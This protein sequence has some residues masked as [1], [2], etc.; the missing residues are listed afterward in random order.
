MTEKTNHRIIIG[1]SRQMK[2][3]NAESVQLI[4]TSPP[5][6]QLKDYGDP[7]QI[8]FDDSYEDYINNL[9]LVW[10]ECNR[11][12]SPGC[13]LCINI[14]DQFA[15][16]VY[17]G[18]YKVI[19]IRT[20]I[21]KFCETI[22][23]DYM[24]AIIWQKVTTTNTTGGATIMGSFPYP[25]NGILK[26]DYEFILIFKKLGTA[27]KPTPYQ[28]EKSK[29]TIDE[30]NE[31]FA[32][33]WNFNG[34]K[35]DKH[36]AM[37]PEELPRRLIRMFSFVGDTILD[38]FLGSG[39]TSLAA[40]NLGRNSIGYEI[41]REFTN[42]IKR[43]LNSAPNDLFVKSDVIMSKQEYLGI[44]YKALINTLPYKYV[45]NKKINK[46]IDP[47][48]IVFGSKITG[49]E[50][51]KAE[52]YRMK[53]VVDADTIE[54]NTGAMIR[55]MGIIPIASMRKEAI[56]YLVNVLTGQDIFLKFDDI[57]YDEQNNLLAYVY[58]K[59]K[60][61]INAKMIKAGFT[62]PAGDY[63]FKYKDKFNSYV[64]QKSLSD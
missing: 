7:N 21:T 28:K 24:G 55:L 64:G 30:W 58:L 57:K 62:S 8:G 22:G 18:R 26:I 27:P 41:N 52:Y 20:E 6:W 63:D 42:I 1:D 9:N 48:K 39:T 44:D 4:I 37:F 17:Y 29:L 43:K 51:H 50:A 19:P 56:N 12:L 53:R 13:R 38:P 32:G 60:T 16:S 33:H 34:E 23:L 49:K 2:E 36:L 15:R 31:Y 40:M 14:G 46:K 61:F 54:L 35:Q 5:Y 25:R 3:V 10:N 47:R 59:N 11:V 45:D